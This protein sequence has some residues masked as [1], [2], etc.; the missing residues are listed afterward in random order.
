MVLANGEKVVKNCK[1]AVGSNYE[2]E[3]NTNSKKRKHLWEHFLEV[4]EFELGPVGQIILF[5]FF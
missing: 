3:D 4:M 2:E 1:W 5:F